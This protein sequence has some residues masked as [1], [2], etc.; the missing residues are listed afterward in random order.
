M[1]LPPWGSTASVAKPLPACVKII[2]IWQLTKRVIL[3]VI[4]GVI[5]GVIYGVI[6]HGHFLVIFCCRDLSWKPASEGALVGS[7]WKLFKLRQISK[8]P[9]LVFIS[10][11][12]VIC[13]W[14]V[15]TYTIVII[16]LVAMPPPQAT[17]ITNSENPV[18]THEHQK[19]TKHNIDERC[20][21]WNP[22]IFVE[23]VFSCTLF[24]PRHLFC[25]PRMYTG[26]SLWEWVGVSMQH[27]GKILH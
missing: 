6:F 15:V 11:Y 12:G 19:I 27:G 3:G 26:W 4:V 5:L 2:S 24:C 10:R 21:L 22:Y 9:Y 18:G 25:P 1:V 14:A 20:W 7:Y 13:R 17:F 8:F 23:D 16:L